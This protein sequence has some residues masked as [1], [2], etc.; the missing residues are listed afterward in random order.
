MG[1]YTDVESQVKYGLEKVDEDR[2][3][4]VSLKDFL[5]LHNIVGEFI[6]FFHQ[7]LHY[8]NLEDVKKFLGDKDSGA[9]NLLCEIYYKKF[10]YRDIFP[11]D[12]K[13]MIDN[14]QFENPDY[15]YYHEP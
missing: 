7:P 11:E 2:K 9:L 14:S 1:K 10:H 6:R 8:K 12:I 13:D 4:E 15:P 3:I 5:L